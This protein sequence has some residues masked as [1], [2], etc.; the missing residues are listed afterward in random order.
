MRARR[1]ARLAHED[2]AMAKKPTS[3]APAAETTATPAAATA[4]TAGQAA[5]AFTERAWKQDEE[6]AE[7][8]TARFA[9]ANA[10]P[11]VA[12]VANPAPSP[13]MD[14]ASGAFVEPA[15]VEGIPADHPSVESNPRQGTSAVQNGIDFNEPYG[16]HPSEAGFAG[17]GIDRSVYGDAAKR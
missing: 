3:A 7:R 6:R 9:E 2:H 5:A 10:L 4:E 8:E 11:A 15:V 12:A 13:T 14:P 1:A 16:R 17:H